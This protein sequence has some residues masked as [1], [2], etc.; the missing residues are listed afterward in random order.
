MSLELAAIQHDIVWENPTATIEVVRPLVLDAA[1]DGA[2]LISLTEMWSC[3]FSMNTDVV[4][5]VPDG[6]TPTAMHALAAETGCWI[7]GS[8]PEHTAGHDRPTN[9]F[10]LAG[11]DGEEPAPDIG[12]I[13]RQVR[14][15]PGLAV[16]P[17]VE[18]FLDRVLVAARKRSEY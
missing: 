5:E 7:A 9:R 16:I 18:T 13:D 12:R 11:P 17:L 8:F 10:L 14:N 1:D 3:G 6:P 15:L 2:H 4:A